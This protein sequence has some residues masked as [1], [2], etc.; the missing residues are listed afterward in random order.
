MTIRVKL[1]NN[2]SAYRLRGLFKGW[3]VICIGEYDNGY[4]V[5]VSLAQWV[6]MLSDGVYLFR[7]D[8]PIGPNKLKR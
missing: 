6:T 5:D 3:W 7:R 8:N 4:E 2:D 1:S